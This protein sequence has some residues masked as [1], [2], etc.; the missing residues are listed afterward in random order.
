MKKIN[1]RRFGLIEVIVV[2]LVTAIFSSLATG[3]IIF[4]KDGSRYVDFSNNTQVKEFLEVYASIIT[5]YYEDVSEE[6]LVN[7][8]INGMFDY[9]GD[10]YSSYLNKKE[11]DALDEKLNGEYEGIGITIG[12]GNVIVQVFENSPAEA[13]GI[14]AGD[15]LTLVNGEDISNKSTEEISGMIKNS[16]QKKV[17]VSVLR[18][19]EKIE[20]T[21]ELKKIEIPSV[22]YKVVN[23]NN[24]KVGYMY[25]DTFG[26]KT[27]G[28]VE[29]ALKAM[30]K[31][32]VSSLIIDVRD[33]TGGYL[34]SAE[35]IAS[36]F[37]AK[38]KVIY[39]MEDKMGISTTKDTTGT[40]REYPIVVLVNRSSASA[41]EI[42]AGALRE[43]YGATIVG[44]TTFGKGKVQQK[45]NLDTGGMVKYTSARW[46]MPNKE[47]IDGIGIKPNYEI[48]P[49]YSLQPTNID[50]ETFKTEWEM[51]VNYLRG[52]S[53]EQYNK[54]VEI[55]AK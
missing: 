3:I 43:S 13:A 14:K 19:S 48:V 55:L 27:V 21:I 24:K 28:Q 6:D 40:K 32:G 1:E 26:N 9:L 51:Y 39:Y 52:I 50:S 36:L 38:G 46:L 29:A 5:G 2:I 34:S 12:T 11:T 42:L 44:E 33:N 30:E 22:T 54:A 17:L 8:A 15:V 31:E 53:E 47:C 16:N 41:S 25:L 7:S 23:Q 4:S 37:L 49:D 35:D 20:V 45:L 10:D 18:G